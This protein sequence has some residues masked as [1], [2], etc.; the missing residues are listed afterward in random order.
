MKSCV[1]VLLL[2]S[3][4]CQVFCFLGMPLSWTSSKLFENSHQAVLAFKLFLSVFPLT[5]VPTWP[6]SAF[7]EEQHEAFLWFSHLPLESKNRPD[8][9]VLTFHPQFLPARL[10]VMSWG[11]VPPIAPHLAYSAK[12]PSQNLSLFLSFGVLFCFSYQSTWILFLSV[13]SSPQVFVHNAAI[14][15]GMR[16]SFW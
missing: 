4:K 3:L 15:A 1:C 9:C 13:S 14:N 16:T 10:P 12:L 7:H 5:N 8:N 2:F 11:Q 6:L